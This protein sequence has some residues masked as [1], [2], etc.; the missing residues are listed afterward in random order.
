MSNYFREH[1]VPEVKLYDDGRTKQAFKD[2]TD[3]NRILAAFQKT[4]AISHL[5]KYEPM[6]GDFESFDFLQAHLQIN[7]GDKIFSELPSEIR[8]EFGQSPAEFF[9]FVNDP[10]N[11]DRLAEVFPVL[12]KPGKFAFDMSMRTPPGGSMDPDAPDVDAGVPPPVA[13]A[14]PGTE[15][16]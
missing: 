6:Y 5:N 4:G 15:G 8:R 13:P 12:A 14:P 1:G 16:A 10:V 11:K 9:R 7:K 2:G 3:I